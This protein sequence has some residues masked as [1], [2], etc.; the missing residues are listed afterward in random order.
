[1]VKKL[2][3]TLL[4]KDLLHHFGRQYWW[5]GETREEIIIGAVLTQNTNWANVEKAINN[6]K[7]K[8][9]LSLNK[10]LR[11]N[12]SRLAKLIKP[13]G[14]YNIKAER[15]RNVAGFFVD[16]INYS[17]KKWEKVDTVVM[18]E[19]LLGVNGVGRETA[20][21]ILNYAFDKKIF[22]IDAY[23]KRICIRHQL[24]KNDATYDELQMFFSNNIKGDVEDY[25][26]LHALIVILGKNYC[27]SKP[28][29]NTC[30][31]NKYKKVIN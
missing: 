29:C 17:L 16:S 13:S 8:G 20:D 21:S 18:R 4:Y 26:E 1:M 2:S 14:Y 15:L 10:I 9:C 19:K 25:K 11:M 30:P 28:N 22:V 31:L 12:R 5:P 23:T 24:V 6:L 3:V 7:K 27:K